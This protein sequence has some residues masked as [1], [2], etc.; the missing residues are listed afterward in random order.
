MTS[1]IRISISNLRLLKKKKKNKLLKKLISH[2]HLTNPPLSVVLVL[3]KS[4]GLD[5]SANESVFYSGQAPYICSP[6]SRL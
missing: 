3:G 4:G 2:V 6:I 5:A 1:F